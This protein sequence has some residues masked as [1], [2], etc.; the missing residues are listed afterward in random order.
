[1]IYADTFSLSQALDLQDAV[2]N[3]EVPFKNGT[4]TLRDICYA[5]LAPEN[6]HCAI[7]SVV[8]YFQNSHENID[9]I[10]YDPTGWLIAADFHDHIMSCVGWV[11]QINWLFDQ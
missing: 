9:K 8:N 3:L 1:M 7:Q 6:T 4:V 5:P 2:V 11:K 10:V